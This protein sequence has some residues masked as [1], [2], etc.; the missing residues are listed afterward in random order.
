[1]RREITEAFG[2]PIV[3]HYGTH[4]LGTVAW[5]CVRKDG[6]HVAD[7]GTV[8]EVL[9][10]DRP[11]QPGEVGEVVATRLHGFAMPFIRYRLGD[12]VTQGETAC[13]CGAPFSTIFTVQG[14]M[15]DYFP[16]ANGRLVHP[17]ELVMIILNHGT[18]WIAQ[19]QLT[20]ER[21]DRVV[22]R[23]VPRASPS[24][25]DIAS[26]GRAAREH[27]GPGVEFHVMLVSDVPLEGNGKFRVS[28]SLV[29]SAYD[30]IDWE[31]RR[32]T[33]FPARHGRAPGT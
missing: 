26:F 7:D 6:F 25:E 28:R 22:L 33:D 24:P 1:M 3:E 30:D 5:Q 8:L 32:A 31:Q 12:L 23:V 15:L 18:R 21:R 4:E 27:L 19:Y 29:E 2:V 17:Y 14:R 16:L 20:Q 13:A 9:K 11:A 10:D